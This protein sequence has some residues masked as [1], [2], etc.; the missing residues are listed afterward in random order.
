[1]NFYS[2]IFLV[3]I[4]KLN[5]ICSI[6]NGTGYEATCL[7]YNNRT[8]SLFTYADAVIK[9]HYQHMRMWVTILGYAG[10]VNNCIRIS[11]I[12]NIYI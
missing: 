1:M 5:K 9:I 11:F 2:F 3:V 12:Y 4:S 8:H 6:K 10:V 7:N